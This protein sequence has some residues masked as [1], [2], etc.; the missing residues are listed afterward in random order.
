MLP[1]LTIGSQEISLYDLFNTLGVIAAYLFNLF[2]YRRKSHVLSTY[3]RLWLQKHPK[4]S[5]AIFIVV[6]TILLSYIQFYL[7]GFC[8]SNWAAFLNGGGA[9]Y[10]GLVYFSPP[11]F[12]L[13]CMLLRINP[14]KQQDLITPSYAVALSFA[15]FACFLHGCCQGKP[16]IHGIYFVMR[17]RFEFP[18]QLLEM[19][20]ALVILYILI[21]KLRRPRIPGSMFPTYLILYSATRFF[22]EFTRDGDVVLL[23]LQTYQIQCV[24]GVLLGVIWL[25]VIKKYGQK[26]SDTFDRK[27]EEYLLAR[28]KGISSEM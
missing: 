13:V 3:S 21:Y 12:L 27:Q 28:K 9:N 10:F 19:A 22:T 5:A 16:W 17:R 2:L 7:G 25:L 4:C 26:W 11:L 23:G 14:L 8:N 18:A 20:V 15:K 6:E 1:Y 24:V